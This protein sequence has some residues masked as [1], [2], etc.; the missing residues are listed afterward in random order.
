M[1]HRPEDEGSRDREG[2]EVKYLRAE[3]RG[4]GAQ[5]RRWSRD[6]KPRGTGSGRET[7]RWSRDQ[8]AAMEQRPGGGD[9]L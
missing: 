4:G 1:E 8:A 2:D 9:V 7:R 3:A 5:T 6:W